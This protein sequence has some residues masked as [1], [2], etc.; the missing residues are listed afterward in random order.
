MKLFKREKE[1]K[2]YNQTREEKILKGI[3][4]AVLFVWSL[5][6]LYP[7]V[8]AI[9]NSF[10]TPIEYFDNSFALPVEW[11]FQNWSQA[12]NKLKV[13]KG[14]LYNYADFWELILNSVWYSVGGNVI[15]LASVSTIAYTLAKYQNKYTKFLYK[16]SLIV[17]MI[18]LMGTMP[19][20]YKLAHQLGI[21]NSPLYLIKSLGALG[22][23]NLLIMYSF[24]SG[25]SWTY[26]EAVFIDGGGHWTVYLKVMLP[27]SVPIL[28]AMFI[29]GWIA[30][31]N[32]Y[33]TPLMYLGKYPTLATGL[34]ILET[35]SLT[36]SNKPMY[37]AALI[38][39]ALPVVLTYSLFSGVINKS[40]SIG[41]IKG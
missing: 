40:V 34:Y 22:S 17:M 21:A 35:G 12:F 2:G 20:S 7:F 28:V 3:V 26:A 38:L 33:L 32:D 25:I 19:A 30:S 1:G 13:P 27:Q 31:W 15:G 23:A 37:F 4:A 18:P 11:R 6:I 29:M 16:L 8:W 9:L 5:T 10:K 36:S 24:F 14:D 41:G 39:S